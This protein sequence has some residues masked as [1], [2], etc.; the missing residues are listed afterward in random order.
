MYID[1]L[2]SKL[3]NESIE[4]RSVRLLTGS[5]TIFFRLIDFDKLTNCSDIAKR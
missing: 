1:I 5:Q 3:F 2:F 4:T